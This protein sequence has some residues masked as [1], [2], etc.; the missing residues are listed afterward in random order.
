VTNSAYRNLCPFGGG[1]PPARFGPSSCRR[2]NAQHERSIKFA[3]FFQPT[4]SDTYEPLPLQPHPDIPMLLSLLPLLLAFVKARFPNALIA[5]DS[6]N[7]LRE[8]APT[9]SPPSSSSL[10]PSFNSSSS[11]TR[12]L[13]ADD[14]DDELAV[15]RDRRVEAIVRS[16]RQAASVSVWC[17]TV[18]FS[19][20]QR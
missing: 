6:G 14:E 10:D 19:L 3:L 12:P 11:V 18:S 20:R 1:Q 2:R 15:I 5:S 8:F 16:T 17:V 4:S 7:G 9:F 13:D